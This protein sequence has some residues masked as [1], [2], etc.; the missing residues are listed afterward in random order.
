LI[1]INGA[2]QARADAGR[3]SGHSD[4]VETL[5]TE[6][7]TLRFAVG[8]FDAWSEVLA[9]VQ[10]LTD[11]GLAESAFS[12]LA[13]QRVLAPVAV[14]A[15][16]GMSFSALPFPGSGEVIA[17]S[18]GPVV[19]RLAAM[20]DAKAET[21]SSALGHWLI[22]RHAAQ[23]EGAVAAGKIILWVQLFDNEEERRACRS[24][25]A[26]SSNSVGV[27]DLVGA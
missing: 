19:D 3:G 13:L 10:E 11:A 9:S 26:K 25:L 20:L 8:I 22:P 12:V 5:V 15:D 27:H 7:T 18:S 14:Y 1:R 21:L 16:R 24:L 6:P 23:L 2:L 17:G 4:Q